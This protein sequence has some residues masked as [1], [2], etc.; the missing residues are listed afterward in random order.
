[1]TADDVARCAEL[2]VERHAA[3]RVANPLY[4]ANLDTVEVVGDLISGWLSSGV[5]IVAEQ[6]GTLIGYLTGRAVTGL[7]G[8][9]MSFMWEWAHATR[10]DAPGTLFSEM[11]T[12]WCRLSGRPETTLHMAIVFA[13][14]IATH[15][16]LVQTGFGRHLIDG[17]RAIG[18]GD[19]GVASDSSAEVSIPTLGELGVVNEMEAGLHAHLDASPIWRPKSPGGGHVYDRTWIERPSRGLWVS[20]SDGR[21]TGFMSAEAG[22]QDPKSLMSP[23]VPHI[24]G[25][26]LKPE[27]RRTGASGALLSALLGWIHESGWKS[28]TVD[29]ETSNPEGARF[30]LG[31]AGFKPLLYTM[32]RRLD[33]RYVS[34]A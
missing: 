16:C 11:Y 1:M 4:P 27:A 10:T 30:W 23:P 34:E 26:F 21:I 15:D 12:A 22:A 24:T 18:A 19:I 2:F 33:P 6:D 14:D 31:P 9:R 17:G 29:F 25:A 8:V 7:G 5:G 3:R 32:L 20:R 28:A 13:D